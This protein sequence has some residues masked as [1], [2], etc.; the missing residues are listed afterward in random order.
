MPIF[1]AP[2]QC[3]CAWRFGSVSVTIVIDMIW[4]FHVYYV[5]HP[6][7]ANNTDKADNKN[8][9]KRTKIGLGMGGRV[10]GKYSRSWMNVAP[11]RDC[12]WLSNSRQ[13][14][15]PDVLS[16]ARINISTLKYTLC[17]RSIRVRQSA[18]SSFRFPLE[19]VS[20]GCC[21]MKR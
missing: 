19:S 11:A 6:V 18:P 17:T 13:T 10:E 9:N 21:V 15:T 1:I 7:D 4:W 12:C 16:V 3:A 14:V 2:S 5:F 20:E 8:N